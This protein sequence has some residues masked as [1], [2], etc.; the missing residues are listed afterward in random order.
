VNDV[1]NKGVDSSAC[2]T[3]DVSYVPNHPSKSTRSGLIRKEEVEIALYSPWMK[4]PILLSLFWLV[5]Q[6]VFTFRS[7]VV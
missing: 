6:V 5:Y 1:Y 2:P 3:H 7:C 4:L